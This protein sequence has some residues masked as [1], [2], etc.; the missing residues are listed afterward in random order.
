MRQNAQ[1]NAQKLRFV[2]TKSPCLLPL[3]F[4]SFFLLCSRVSVFPPTKGTSW[5][6]K[7]PKTPHSITRNHLTGHSSDHEWLFWR[8]RLI[9]LGIFA[10]KVSGHDCSASSGELKNTHKDLAEVAT[11]LNSP[12]LFK[13]AVATLSHF[14]LTLPGRNKV[15]ATVPDF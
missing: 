9:L 5:P 4:F 11:N 8:H 15:G 14:M 6:G 3:R 12:W 7:P 10:T 1:E 2:E 13:M